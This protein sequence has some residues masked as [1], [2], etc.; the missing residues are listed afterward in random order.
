MKGISSLML[1]TSCILTS[2]GTYA[3][4]KAEKAEVVHFPQ[5]SIATIVKSPSFHDGLSA[6]A[7]EGQSAE[8]A[9]KSLAKAIDAV[10][11]LQQNEEQNSA[12]EQNPMSASVMLNL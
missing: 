7:E 2:A 1:I 11:D 10:R 8:D 4:E 9:F 3:M 12:E 5:V 6:V